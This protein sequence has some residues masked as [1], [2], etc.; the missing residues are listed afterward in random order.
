MF[1]ALFVVFVFSAA[2]AVD[3]SGI[4]LDGPTT[5]KPFK[6]E[7]DI[8]HSMEE[9]YDSLRDD[10]TPAPTSEWLASVRLAT[11]AE[12][13][14]GNPGIESVPASLGEAKTEYPTGLLGAI[15]AVSSLLLIVG[16]AQ[17]WVLVELRKAARRWEVEREEKYKCDKA[18]HCDLEAGQ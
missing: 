3:F 6:M 11:T 18:P 12:P 5:A 2:T 14:S 1:H 9:F 15:L 7:G 17:L 16:I 13:S 8:S 4:S 10:S